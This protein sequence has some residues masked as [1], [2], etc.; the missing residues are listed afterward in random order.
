[1][2]EIQELCALMKRARLDLSDEKRTQNDLAELFS[3][4]GVEFKREV[5][6]GPGEIVD[7]MVADIAIEV[8]MNRARKKSIFRQL[9]RYAKSPDVAVLVL[10]TNIG[11]G[12]P[13]FIGGKPVYY[14]S[15]GSA[16]L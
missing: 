6:L 10:V 4:Q 2:P 16:W 13:E 9:E 3:S 12:L 5:R 7:F 8:K 15:L 11:M 1:M 14:I